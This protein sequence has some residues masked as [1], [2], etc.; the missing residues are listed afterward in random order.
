MPALVIS[1]RPGLSGGPTVGAC[2]LGALQMRWANP[3]ARGPG[4]HGG[5]STVLPCRP[6]TRTLAFPG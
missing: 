4:F 6:P 2:R 1:R 5:F 3:I